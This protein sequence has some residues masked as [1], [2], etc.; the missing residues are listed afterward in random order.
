VL[1]SH[2]TL[3]KLRNKGDYSDLADKTIA[4]QTENKLVQSIFIIYV[5]RSGKPALSVLSV[6]RGTLNVRA[7]ILMIILMFESRYTYR[8]E[9]VLRD[10][11]LRSVCRREVV[12][13]HFP[14]PATVL[15]SRPGRLVQGH[16]RLYSRVCNK[17][18]AHI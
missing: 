2:L 14:S 7:L 16:V 8:R 1:T 12:I 15:T 6:R 17:G 3:T 5:Q 13:R 4:T 18:A 9:L 10:R 11:I